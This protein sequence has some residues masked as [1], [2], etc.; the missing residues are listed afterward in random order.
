MRHFFVIKLISLYIP[1]FCFLVMYCVSTSIYRSRKYSLMKQFIE[2]FNDPPS[3]HLASSLNGRRTVTVF[4]STSKSRVYPTITLT[5]SFST[6]SFTNLGLRTLTTKFLYSD[7]FQR[8]YVAPMAHSIKSFGVIIVIS[9][10][11]PFFYLYGNRF[12]ISFY[13]ITPQGP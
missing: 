2:T 1:F 13:V 3:S 8:K 6:N 4:F 9:T 7:G 5:F 12:L 10:I 11:C